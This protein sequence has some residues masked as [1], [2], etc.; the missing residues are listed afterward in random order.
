MSAQVDGL[1]QLL[2]EITR[3]GQQ[4]E[5]RTKEKALKAGGN[6]LKG[7]LKEN[8]PVVTGN[9]RDNIIVSDVKNDKVDV[10]ADQ[11]GDAFYGYFHEFGTS[12]MEARPVYGPTL[13]S[14]RRTI[15]DEMADEIRRN[16][17]L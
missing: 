2:S 6:Y 13:E 11:Q 10:G 3:M 14:E 9:W 8:V 12:K 17:G 1:N 15:R 7:K 4:A 16:L 5:G